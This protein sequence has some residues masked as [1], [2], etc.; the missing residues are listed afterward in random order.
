M[1]FSIPPSLCLLFVCAIVLPCVAEPPASTEVEVLQQKVVQQ[2]GRTITYNLVQPPVLPVRPPA[3]PP[4]EVTPLTQEELAALQA[5]ALKPVKSVIVDGTTYANG[6]TDFRWNDGDRAYRAFSNVD[7]TVFPALL[8]LSDPSTA[9]QFTF[10]VGKQAGPVPNDVPSP[11]QFSASRA[12]YLVA[13]LPAASAPVEADLTSID[14]LHLY[15]D[16]A[17][18]ELLAAQ[19]A[20]E[21]AQAAQ[22]QALKENPPPPKD[23]TIN[24]WPKKSR[25]YLSP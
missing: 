12:E 20:R 25:T 5:E 23:V 22:E 17:K 4:R 9:Y 6:I 24:F 18:A 13:S 10:L 7:F 16:G 8:T 21:A 2:G 15:Y 19:T 3:Q 1:K 11:G 14:L